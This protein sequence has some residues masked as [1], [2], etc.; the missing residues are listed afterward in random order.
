MN[1]GLTVRALFGATMRNAVWRFLATVVRGVALCG[2][3]TF[4]RGTGGTGSDRDAFAKCD[5]TTSTSS[6]S[7][8][9][10]RAPLTIMSAWR[11]K[12]TA[13]YVRWM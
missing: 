10:S 12:Q 4:A 1:T 3:L 6:T 5:S 7:G 8:T 2:V 13:S 11:C 9:A